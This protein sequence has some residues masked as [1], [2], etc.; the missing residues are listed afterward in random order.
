MKVTEFDIAVALATDDSEGEEDLRDRIA[1]F[2]D[3]S[4]VTRHYVSA[5]E[6]D[7]EAAIAPLGEWM[8]FAGCL[9]EL[10][11]APKKQRFEDLITQVF[12]DPHTPPQQRLDG[13]LAS[14]EASLNRHAEFGAPTRSTLPALP[15]VHVLAGLNDDLQRLCEAKPTPR[16]QLLTDKLVTAYVWRA[17]CTNRYEARAND[18]LFKDFEGLKQCIAEISRTGSFDNDSLPPIFDPKENP[19]P[20]HATLALLDEDKALAWIR[21]T[22]HRARAI[23]SLTLQREAIDWATGRRLTQQRVRSLEGE[24]ALHRHHVF[25]KALLQKHGFKRGQINHGLNGVL[26]SETTNKSFSK[27]DPRD[28]LAALL[29]EPPRPS[30]EELRTWVE[31][32]LVPYNIIMADG[33]VE[34][35]YRRFISQRAR[36]V[37]MELKKLT[38]LPT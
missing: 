18:K 4:K 12:K 14:V 35:R 26:L 7:P 32:H 20:N 38:T 33:P 27:A 5:R 31:S 36:L 15:P 13:F 34:D 9:A 22:D 2:N 23:A 28:Y 1:A 19:I 11:V 16:Q 3:Q 10:G 8:L 17:F 29:D 6:H 24:R 25:P 37:E 30:K 21:S